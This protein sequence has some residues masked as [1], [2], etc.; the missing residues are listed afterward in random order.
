MQIN[1][2]GIGSIELK[3]LVFDYNGTIARDGLVMSNLDKTITDLAGKI[4]IHILTA[5]SGGTVAQ[6]VSGLPCTLHIITSGNEAEQ[7]EAYVQALGIDSVV[8]IGNGAND[9]LMLKAARLGIAVLEGEGCAVSA[10][11]QADIVARSIYDALGLL[12]VPQRISATLRS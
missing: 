8:C 2:P 12:M 7:K 3:H 10:I 1:I 5:D 6:E 9:R 11:L 4:T